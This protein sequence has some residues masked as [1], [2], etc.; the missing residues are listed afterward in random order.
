MELPVAACTGVAI[1]VHKGM[2]CI[3]LHNIAIKVTSV[4]TNLGMIIHMT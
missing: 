1:T 3:T 4:E 2:F